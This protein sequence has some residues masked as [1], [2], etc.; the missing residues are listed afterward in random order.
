MMAAGAAA[1]AAAAVTLAVVV[2]ARQLAGRQTA[3]AGPAS[4][5]RD[6]RSRGDRHAGHQDPDRAY[7]LRIRSRWPNHAVLRISDHAP[8]SQTGR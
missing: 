7:V 2:R 3:P 6:A 4:R 8:D 1:A 5:V